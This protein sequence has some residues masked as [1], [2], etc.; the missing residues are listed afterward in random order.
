MTKQKLESIKEQ[1]DDEG[2]FARRIMSGESDGYDGAD[3]ARAVLALC[4]SMALMIAELEK[5]I[6]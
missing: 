4:R 1:M 2:N 3:G 5:H 6:Q